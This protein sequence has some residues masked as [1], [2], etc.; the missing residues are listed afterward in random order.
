MCSIITTVSASTI[1]SKI[2]FY[3]IS[4]KTI[5]DIKAEIIK[6]T[7]I[8][9]NGVKFH[10]STT[11]QIKWNISWKSKNDICYLDTSS[12]TLKVEFTMPRISLAMK[13]VLNVSNAFDK[14]YQAL[15][16]H[17]KGHMNN[18]EKALS[19][20]N[21]LLENFSS[22]RECNK[23]NNAVKSSITGVVN[24]YKHL[25]SVYDEKT[26]HGKLQGV[27]FKGFI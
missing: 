10:G 16:T 25:D 8:K 26:N 7:P 12:A 11:W 6:N 13:P 9:S 18:G 23:L 5:P 3:D 15:L 20:V 2:N 27:S 24:K 4:P 22:Y 17:E 21:Q 1:N 14:Y 19:E